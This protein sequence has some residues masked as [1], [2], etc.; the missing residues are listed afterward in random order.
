MD[1]CHFSY[2]TK[3]EKRKEKKKSLVRIDYFIKKL[4]LSME[5]PYTKPVSMGPVTHLFF[6]MLGRY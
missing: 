5:G 2:I 6:P 1:D 4:E 3:L